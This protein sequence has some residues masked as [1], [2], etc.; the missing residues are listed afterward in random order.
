M[1]PS[2][3]PICL[4]GLNT[5][6]LQCH[7]RFF[8]IGVAP[9]I[10]NVTLSVS[11][12]LLKGQETEQAMPFL[13]FAIVVGCSLQ[14]LFT[15]VPTVHI[16]KSYFMDGWTKGLNIFSSEIRRL[17]KPLSL[18][19]LGIGASQINNAMDALFARFADP[20]GPAQL[21]FSLRLQ[22]LPLALFGIALS[23]AILPPLSRAVQA[24]KKNEFLSFL[25]FAIRKTTALLAP[26][27]AYLLV[28][29]YLIVHCIYARGDFQAHSVLSTTACLHGYTLGLIPM[30]LVVIF[31]PA[32]FAKKNYSIPAKAALFSLLMNGLFDSIFVF[33]LGMKAVSVAA[34]TCLSSCLNAAYLS[35]H[36]KKTWG[37]ILSHSSFMCCIKIGLCSVGA[38]MITFFF[39]GMTTG[40]PLLFSAFPESCASL[41][42]SMYGR[43][44]QL[45][46]ASFIFLGS[47]LGLAQL[48][49]V[50]D[51]FL[52]QLWSRQ[53]PIIPEKP[54]QNDERT[55]QTIS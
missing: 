32:F 54:V 27:T 35:Y 12:L 14:W 13:A 18:G 15:M 21:W 29:G 45:A 3:L 52:S 22:Q 38:F 11:A 24:E 5:S 55:S 50:E 48:F 37:S 1:L 25:D 42:E 30:G 53:K 10:F 8:A 2:L 16:A 40:Y 33:G 46:I 17:W 20:E 19:M 47:L 34:A 26:C 39:L 7:K 51:L 36:L 6:L 43:I 44:Y 9:S 28:L 41:P 23:S 4:F 31:A 49:K